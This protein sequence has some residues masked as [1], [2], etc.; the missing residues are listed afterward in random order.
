MPIDEE[1]ARIWVESAKD[2]AFILLDTE[3]RVSAWN[4]GA[5]R[6]L[7]YREAEILGQPSKRFFTP[8]DAQKG[9]AEWELGEALSKGQSYDDRWHVRKDGTWFWG[10]G[11]VTPLRGEGGAFRGFVKVMRDL[12]E[13]KRLEDE[14]RGQAERMRAADRRKD[15]FLA[16]LSHELRNPL[17]PIL[18]ALYVI[19]QGGTE[20]PIVL[21]SAA[22]IERQV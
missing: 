11:V 10:S 9:E 6:I 4:A 2:Y 1:V 14:L 15:E 3:G 18:N 12:T 8:E 17:A 5:E 22:M 13:H 7:G 16:M 20:D 21:Q 19:R